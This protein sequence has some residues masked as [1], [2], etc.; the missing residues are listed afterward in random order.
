MVAL[1][2]MLRAC[3]VLA[4]FT[5][6]L[7]Q[8]ELGDVRQVRANADTPQAELGFEERL[9][10]KVANMKEHKEK[11]READRL[12]IRI[13][14]VTECSF[15]DVGPQGCFNPTTAYPTNPRTYLGWDWEKQYTVMWSNVD[16]QYP[17][18][19]QWET[20]YCGAVKKT[21][22]KGQ[23]E[24]SFSFKQLAAEFSKSQCDYSIEN[25]RRLANSASNTIRVL[26]PEKPGPAH[27]SQSIGDFAILDRVTQTAI[28]A[29]KAQP[30][31]CPGCETPSQC[32][33]WTALSSYSLVTIFLLF[34]MIVAV[35]HLSARLFRR[36]R[37][38]KLLYVPQ[39][40]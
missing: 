35:L 27:I 29:V 17:L 16:G 24:F 11:L 32:N 28:K 4:L 21:I 23:N 22:A 1:V 18:Q 40:S 5:L 19:F 14:K 7:C 9:A 15:I 34:I 8:A 12:N 37:G 20:G 31:T 38:V 33:L 10:S 2:P 25:I 30:T 26:Q 3:G 6:P 13:R 36:D 39:L